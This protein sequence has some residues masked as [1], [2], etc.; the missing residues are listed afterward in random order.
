[1]IEDGQSDQNKPQN[2]KNVLLDQIKPQQKIKLWDCG[3]TVN[4]MLNVLK[5]S[6]S[7]GRIVSSQVILFPAVHQ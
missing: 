7:A 6:L 4:Y 1:M 3:H 2:L 5:W